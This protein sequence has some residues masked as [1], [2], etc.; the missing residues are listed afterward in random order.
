MRHVTP[1]VLVSALVMVC[2]CSFSASAK[3]DVVNGSFET[4]D[5]TGWTLAGNV[6]LLPAF[7]TDGAWTANFNYG[8]AVPN[9]TLTQVV[10]TISGQTYR[11]RFDFGVRSISGANQAL[12]VQVM[13]GQLLASSQVSDPSLAATPSLES[14]DLFFVADGPSAV[15]SFADVSTNATFSCD[16]VLDNIHLDAI[17]ATGRR[18]WGAVKSSSSK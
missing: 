10:A 13:G 1:R 9:A 3:A 12:L 2:A 7:A 4:G 6:T 5:F 14:Y 8:N 18:T 15:I 11:L 17:T 16:G